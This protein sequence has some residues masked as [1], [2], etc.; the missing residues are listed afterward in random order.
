MA[1]FMEHAAI[2]ELLDDYWSTDPT[3]DRAF[4][5]L[6]ERA[7]EKGLTSILALLYELELGF[8]INGRVLSRLE[9]GLI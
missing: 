2:I 7:R 6:V 4:S 1:A 9:L 8:E 3:T 5:F